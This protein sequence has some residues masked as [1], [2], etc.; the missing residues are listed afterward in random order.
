M[1]C[2]TAHR[3][4]PVDTLLAAERD[5]LLEGIGAIDLLLI[6]IQRAAVLPRSACHYAVHLH[7][8]GPPAAGMMLRRR[9]H[10]QH[11]PREA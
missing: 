7:H 9:S 8:P 4:R 10:G 1:R 3:L 5:E 11:L 6:H 2:L